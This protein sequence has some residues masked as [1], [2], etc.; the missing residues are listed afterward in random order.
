ACLQDATPCGPIP[1]RTENAHIN[2]K[3][4]GQEGLVIQF[5]IKRQVSAFMHLQFL[6]PRYTSNE[7]EERMDMTSF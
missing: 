5:I 6:R 4:A 7:I 2:L 3:V 1:K